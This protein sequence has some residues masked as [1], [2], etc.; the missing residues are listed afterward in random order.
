MK[1]ILT[2]VL[3]VLLTPCFGQDYT[4]KFDQVMTS[5]DSTMQA[6]IDMMGVTTM[7]W[8]ISGKDF[9]L[10]TEMG[11]A[12][13]TNLIYNGASE[14]MLMLMENPFIG[15]TYSMIHDSLDTPEANF[16]VV[17]TKETK[18]IAGYKCN[19]YTIESSD[20]TQSIVYAAPKIPAASKS[21]YSGQVEGTIL[22]TISTIRSGNDKIESV[23]TATEVVKGKIAAEKF[24]LDVPEGFTEFDMNSFG[25]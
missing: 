5:T 19:K 8:F 21:L 23:Q 13:T 2:L 4:I 25:E 11:M 24:S 6:T 14:A 7:T 16:T 9:R 1:S 18:K 15:N 3:V 20:G 17:K 22:C 10:E 12:G